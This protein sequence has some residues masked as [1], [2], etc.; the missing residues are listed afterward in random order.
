MVDFTMSVDLDALGLTTPISSSA[1]SSS[2]SHTSSTAVHPS[3]QDPRTLSLDSVIQAKLQR[4]ASGGGD[5]SSYSST[6]S[7]L[8]KALTSHAGL[9]VGPDLLSWGDEHRRRLVA[10]SLSA[11]LGVAPPTT[12]TATATSTVT[13]TIGASQHAIG[14]SNSRRASVATKGEAGAGGKV[15]SLDLPYPTGKGRM[16]F[17]WDETQGPMSGGKTTASTAST[18]STAVLMKAVQTSSQSLSTITATSLSAAAGGGAGAAGGSGDLSRPSIIS[19]REQFGFAT[20]T[21]GGG[22]SMTMPNQWKIGGTALSYSTTSASS[23]TSSLSS[24]SPAA[25]SSLSSVSAPNPANAAA[26]PSAQSVINLALDDAR[27]APLSSGLATR[28]EKHYAHSTK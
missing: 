21:N 16:A 18:A 28:I 13:G 23:S 19:A 2:S 17:R 27:L 22:M 11:G 9:G 20:Q 10:A 8:S 7:S 14:E 4:D 12:T 25:S 15:A 6:S 26:A 1:S 5:P 3:F 24:P